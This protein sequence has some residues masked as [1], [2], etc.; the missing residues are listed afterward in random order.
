MMVLFFKKILFGF[1]LLEIHVVVVGVTYIAIYQWKHYYKIKSIYYLQKRSLNY[2]LYD[3]KY[4]KYNNENHGSVSLYQFHYIFKSLA[5]KIYPFGGKNH[6]WLNIECTVNITSSLLSGPS[7]CLFNQPKYH[8][9]K[10]PQHCWLLLRIPR[11]KLIGSLQ[12]TW[13]K[14]NK[15]FSKYFWAFSFF[16]SS[17]DIF[18]EKK[19]C[20][21]VAF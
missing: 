9:F 15:R 8:K 21:L 6:S 12:V 7:W 17:H 16:W 10:R 1:N 19:A 2:F 4:N 14:P 3:M 20:I 13:Y 11:G 5:I 18:G